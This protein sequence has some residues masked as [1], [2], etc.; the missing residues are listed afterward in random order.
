MPLS[1]FWRH[2][3][4]RSRRVSFY[5]SHV[6]REAFRTAGPVSVSWLTDE[7]LHSIVENEPGSLRAEIARHELDLRAA[8]NDAV[9]LTDPPA[10]TH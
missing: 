8:R 7:A 3:K 2:L 9:L 1:R 4:R 5:D 10:F 6:M